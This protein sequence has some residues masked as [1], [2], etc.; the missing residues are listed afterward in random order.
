MIRVFLLAFVFGASPAFARELVLQAGPATVLSEPTRAP[1]WLGRIGIAGGTTPDERVE[2]AL[3][4]LDWTQPPTVEDPLRGSRASLSV[5][6]L[7]L[8]PAWTAAVPMLF[9]GLD[10]GLGAR[11]R[12]GEART[13][14]LPSVGGH[15]GAGVR[16]PLGTRLFAPLALLVELGGGPPAVATTIGLGASLD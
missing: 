7:K 6:Y 9:V 12:L 15:F 16:V 3:Q 10:L 2:L 13:F 5:R 1:G 8:F 14:G 4:W 11:A